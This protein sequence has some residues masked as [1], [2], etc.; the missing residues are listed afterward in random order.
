MVGEKP[1]HTPLICRISAM[2]QESSAAR[3]AAQEAQS[4]IA[5][6]QE[7]VARKEQESHTNSRALERKEKLYRDTLT[8][9]ELKVYIV[10]RT[11]DKRLV[12]FRC[13]L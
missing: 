11:E 9:I 4:R 10:Q 7:M 13:W 8:E 2:S 12:D 6:L 1:T 5:E 3:R